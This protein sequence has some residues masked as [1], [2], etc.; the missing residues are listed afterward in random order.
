MQGR[1]IQCDASREAFVTSRESQAVASTLSRAA[2]FLVA[3]INEGE[4]DL[5]A[6]RTM[7][8]DLP[9]FVRAV[10]FR[11]QTSLSEKKS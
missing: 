11:D 9:G 10:G 6:V 2:I 3:F 7:C 1:Q 5:N 4:G 8:G